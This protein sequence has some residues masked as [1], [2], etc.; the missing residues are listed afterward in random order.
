MRI[1]KSLIPGVFCAGRES[2]RSLFCLDPRIVEITRF[3]AQ[4][5]GQIY[6]VRRI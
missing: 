2:M 3:V 5:N 1:N 6:D 4:S